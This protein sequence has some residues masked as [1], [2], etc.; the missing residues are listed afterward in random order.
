MKDAWYRIA[1]MIE[2]DAAHR[3]KGFRLGQMDDDFIL[4]HAKDEV[5][6]LILAKTD[7]ERLDELADVFGCLIHYAIRKG[8]TEE[9]VESA[10]ED[11][12]TQRFEWKGLLTDLKPGDVV[13]DS[14]GRRLRVTKTHHSN[15]GLYW[16]D[17][18]DSSP[19]NGKKYDGVR[20]DTAREPFTV[21]PRHA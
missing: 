6:E 15:D 2:D 21:E 16:G 1:R 20:I 19:W 4:T 8:W 18:V 9:M 7:A 17:D 5:T 3:T 11:K 10:L 14:C 12:L 13:M